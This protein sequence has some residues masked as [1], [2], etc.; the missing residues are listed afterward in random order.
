[1]ASTNFSAC[2]IEGFVGGMVLDEIRRCIPSNE[3]VKLLAKCGYE[4]PLKQR[5]NAMS[6]N[7]GQLPRKWISN[8]L[9]GEMFT[10]QRG[11]AVKPKRTER[12]KNIPVIRNPS[13]LIESSWAS[14]KDV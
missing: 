12:V 2:C 13:F 6:I 8:V 14:G 5:S 3:F 7:L 9:R 4:K 10:R 11:I 1:M